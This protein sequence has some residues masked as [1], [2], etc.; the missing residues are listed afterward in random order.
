MF[1]VITYDVADD[2]L[3][4]RVAR[5]LEGFGQRV[6]YSVFECHLEPG[7][8]RRLRRRLSAVFEAAAPGDSVRFYRLCAGCE[9]RAH[10]WGAGAI[11][12]DVAYFIA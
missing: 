8:Y 4:T 9:R 7:R 1:Y 5:V 6:Q 2:R 12:E 3:R 10:V 11:T